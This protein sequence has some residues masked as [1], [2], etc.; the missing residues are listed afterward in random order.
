MKELYVVVGINSN[1]E[2]FIYYNELGQEEDIM[3]FTEANALHDYLTVCGANVRL[4]KL[5]WLD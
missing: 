3:E 2:P 1:D 5:T 4:A